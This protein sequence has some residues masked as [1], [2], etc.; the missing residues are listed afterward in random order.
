MAPIVARPN[1]QRA[2]SQNGSVDRG[3]PKTLSYI[4]P[5]AGVGGGILLWFGANHPWLLCVGVFAA[6]VAFL[7]VHSKGGPSLSSVVLGTLYTVAYALMPTVW[8][9]IATRFQDVLLPSV[10]ILTALGAIS[11][12]VYLGAGKMNARCVTWAFLM[13]GVGLSTAAFSGPQG[14]PGVFMR[15]LI[16]VLNLDH[17]VAEALT[18]FGRKAVHLVTYGVLA[19]SAGATSRSTTGS[20]TWFWAGLLWALPHAVLD[21][22]HQTLAVNRS[23][24]LGDVAL[25]AA[26]MVVALMVARTLANRKATKE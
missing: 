22:R 21:E 14:G 9:G 15:F 18:F 25:D 19:L 3:T 16:N 6:W 24:S 2:P 12:V 11:M 20:A 5:A 7:I 26:G 4:V 17:G 10:S 23:G 13:V 1:R 8:D